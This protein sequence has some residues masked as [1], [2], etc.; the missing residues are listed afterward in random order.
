MAAQYDDSKKL[1]LKGVVTKFDWANPHVF[2]YLDVDAA[3]WA[4]EMDSRIDLKRAGWTKDSLGVGDVVTVEGG[5]ARDGAKSVHGLSLTL[6]S[7]RKL[8]GVAPAIVSTKSNQPVPRWPD[9]HPRLGPEPGETGYWANPSGGSLTETSANI[10]VNRDGLLANIADAP[11]AAPFLPWARGLYTY[12]QKSLL[13]DDPMGSCLPPGGPRQFQTGNGLQIVE[14]PDRK[15]IFVMSGGGDR[16]WRL[17]NLDGRALPTGDDVSPTYYGHSV[18]KW[19]GDALVIDST[20]Y[21]E[22]FWFTNGGLPHT[23][24]LKLRERISRPDFNTLKY[25]V[26][27]TDPGAYTRPWTGGWTLSWIAGQEIEEYFCDDNNRDGETA[28]AK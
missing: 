15:R 24:S 9:G 16:N 21:N 5:S 8:S 12:R 19:E 7:G 3:T 26:T 4:V 10:R 22:R 17:I 18:G 20:A 28:G 6:P 11:K 25:E 2:V 14:Q 13:K 23:E 1:T 27:V